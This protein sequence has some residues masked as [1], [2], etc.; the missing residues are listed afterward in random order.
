[1]AAGSVTVA[2]LRHRPRQ[3]MLV[4]ALAAVV[5]GAAAL[6]PLYARAVEQSVVRNVVQDAAPASSTLVV[7]DRS[8][9]PAAPVELARTVRGAVPPQFGAPDRWRRGAACSW[10]PAGAGEPVRTRLTSRDGICRHVTAQR[11]PLPPGGRRAAGQ[12]P[13][14][15]DRRAAPGRP[16]SPCAAPTAADGSRIS[17][18]ATVV[19]VYDLADASG[20]YWAGRGAP[21][22]GRP[23]RRRG[24]GHARPST[25]CSPTWATLAAQ[26]WPDL[27]DPPGHPAAGRPDR[28]ARP[29][30][31]A[32]SDGGR[33]RAGRH[34]RRL[35]GQL[36]RPAARLD[37]RAAAPGAQRDPAAGRAAGRARHRGPG[38][39]LRRGHR[40]ATTRDRAGPPA[41]PRQPRGRR[42][43][44]AR[45]RACW[46]SPAA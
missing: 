35:G 44:A 19:G 26:P 10:T 40:A 32:G 2:A 43:A 11:R 15:R 38:V 29:G 31:G 4:V 23:G 28:P 13:D 33:R 41:R 21:P 9:P 37:H 1:M 7:T 34:R 22:T 12:R 8:D 46:C 16:P 27:H 6:G 39:R 18:P 30:D 3:A 14:R 20:R 36:D 25:T 5:T 45:A 24:P 42:D 17:A